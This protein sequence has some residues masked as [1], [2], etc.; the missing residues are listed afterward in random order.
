VVSY[1][2]GV[3]DVV[4]PLIEERGLLAQTTLSGGSHRAIDFGPR[5]AEEFAFVNGAS[6]WRGAR[7]ALVPYLLTNLKATAVSEEKREALVAVAL[8]LKTGA[9]ADSLVPIVGERVAEA[10]PPP[11]GE[12]AISADGGASSTAPSGETFPALPESGWQRLTALA[13]RRARESFAE[14]EKS[15]ARRLA[16]DVDRL[17]DY[18]TEIEREIEKKIQRKRLEGDDE[19]RERARMEA[20]GRELASRLADQRAR[21]AMTIRLEPVAFLKVWV[22]AVLLELTLLR[23]KRSRDVEW[24][25]NHFTREIERPA[26]EACFEPVRRITLCDEKLHLLCQDCAPD[27]VAACA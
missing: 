3:L 14:F 18:Y 17:T 10:S 12:E 6:R 11:A 9:P 27:H 13:G 1:H 26:C 24:T 20:T 22:P 15:L 23:R 4:R 8:N 2:S 19:A 16:R 7:E 5:L 25:Y 21:Y